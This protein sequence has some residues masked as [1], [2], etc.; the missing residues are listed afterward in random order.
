MPRGKQGERRALI[1][2]HCRRIGDGRGVALTFANPAYS[3]ALEGARCLAVAIGR[4][5]SGF[6][7]PMR[8]LPSSPH[9]RSP[10]EIL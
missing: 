3:E 7:T 2:R 1:Q 8:N 5:G 6:F 4:M 9:R 10:D